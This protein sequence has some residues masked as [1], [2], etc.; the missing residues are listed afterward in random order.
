MYRGCL[1]RSGS[2]DFSEMLRQERKQGDSG[3]LQKFKGNEL[4]AI[5]VRSGEVRVMFWTSYGSTYTEGSDIGVRR[6]EK[7][8][9]DLTVT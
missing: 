8:E 3:L 4:H 2:E 9:D 1:F 5:E 7:I 6:C